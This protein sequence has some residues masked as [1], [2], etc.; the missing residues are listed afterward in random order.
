MLSNVGRAKRNSL[1]SIVVFSTLTFSIVSYHFIKF[2]SSCFVNETIKH[3]TIGRML[4]HL[5]FP[6]LVGN[7]IYSFSS[8]KIKSVADEN[9][10]VKIIR[11][12]GNKALLVMFIFYF[13]FFISYIGRISKSPENRRLRLESQERSP[14]LNSL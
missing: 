12:S 2:C 5:I 3:Q 13:I 14:M 7:I 11:K 6:F 10:Q 8:R 9:E 4:F 1:I